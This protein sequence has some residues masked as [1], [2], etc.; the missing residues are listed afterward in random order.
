MG[1]ESPVVG[2]GTCSQRVTSCLEE[3]V[4][5]GSALREAFFSVQ[6]QEVARLAQ[7]LAD[8]LG[9]G[10]K[11]LLCGNGG[12]AADAQHLAAEFV[13]RFLIDRRPLPALALTTDTSIL[14]AV[15]NDFGFA[16]VFAKQVQALGREGDVL[17]GFS[18]SGNSPNV[19]AALEVGR[20][21]GMVT[22][23]L[24]GEGG[25][26]MRDLCDHLLAVPSRQTP[27]IQEIHITVG[28]LLC[29]LTDAILFGE[30]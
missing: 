1:V 24:T 14:T 3:Y 9:Q 30:E 18:T 12:S 20:A 4:A 11:I 26:A 13:N 10:R 5:Q 27:L 17:L 23:G 25:G 6:G 7:V 22:M 2:H 16:Q 21:L 29:L 28:H 8:A 15:G 19:L